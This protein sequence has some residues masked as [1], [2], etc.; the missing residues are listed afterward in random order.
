MV[1]ILF[2]FCISGSRFL[3]FFMILG[4]LGACGAHLGKHVLKSFG[5]GLGFGSDLA[6]SWT[7]FPARWRKRRQRKPTVFERPS[8][9]ALA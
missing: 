4:G 5:F 7:R 2:A 6:S 1:G 9:T 8:G 3:V